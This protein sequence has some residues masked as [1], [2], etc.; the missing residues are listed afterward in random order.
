MRKL[1]PLIL[2]ALVAAMALP[3]VASAISP[4]PFAVAENFRGDLVMVNN[5][6]AWQDVSCVRGCTPFAVATTETA[7][8]VLKRPHGRPTELARTKLVNI[9]GGSNSILTTVSFAASA[10]RTV[11]VRSREENIGDQLSSS[12]T[13]FSG[14]LGSKPSR[15]V[16]CEE[17][18]ELPFALDDGHLAYDDSRCTTGSSDVVVRSL[19]DGTVRRVSLPGRL[20]DTVGL[21]GDRLAVLSYPRTPTP[22]SG[23]IAVFDLTTGAQTSSAATGGP[24]LTPTVLDIRAD[25][26]VAYVTYPPTAK[27][28]SCRGTL[29]VLAPGAAPRTLASGVCQL[30]KLAADEVVAKR[31]T[32]LV[33]IPLSGSEHTLVNLGQVTVVAADAQN[34]KVGYAMPT[35]AGDTAIRFTDLATEPDDAGPAPCPLRIASGSSHVAPNRSFR[36]RLRCRRGCGGFVSLR[37]Q[38]ATLRGEAVRARRR[39]LLGEAAADELADGRAAPTRKPER[40]HHHLHG[41][42]RRAHRALCAPVH[43]RALS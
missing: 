35:C 6:V 2:S 26:T 23:E 9:P 33:A 38:G 24:G 25:G 27:A 10:S 19:A 14:A 30:A 8:F 21:A 17:A 42:P 41:R 5:G 28:A 3:Q 15:L 13:I 22:D 40:A 1:A 11:M 32:K 16:S 43:P 4:R 18:F 31:K 7:R 29:F 37:R 34:T 12:A 20:V 39:V 36:V